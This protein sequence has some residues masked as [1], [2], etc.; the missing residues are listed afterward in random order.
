[1]SACGKKQDADS[2]GTSVR[3]TEAGDSVSSEN[4]D[5][6]ELDSLGKIETKENL[7]SVEVTLP[8]EYV[9][10]T[11]QEKLDED[12]KKIGYKVTLNEDGSAT[13]KL[14]KA[15]HKKVLENLTE[16]IN[17]SMAEMENSEEYPTFTNIEANAD[18]TKFTVTTTSE[19][20]GLNETFSVMIFYT[21]GGMYNIFSGKDVDNIHVD[22][23]NADTGEIISSGDSSDL[24]EE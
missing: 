16:E 21:Y 20:L 15:Q 2:S 18:F 13:Y 17:N 5:L 8:A 7:M 22:F 9:G 24:G 19:E 3:N 10:E 6:T 4:E 14:T 1:M 12:A 23:V 11:S